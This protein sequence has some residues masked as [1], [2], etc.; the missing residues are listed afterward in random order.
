M[1]LHNIQE[2]T[3]RRQFIDRGDSSLKEETVFVEEGDSSSSS[4]IIGRWDT[5]HQERT[6]VIQEGDNSL[7][8][9][10]GDLLME[11]VIC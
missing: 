8:I 6:L 2:G 10:G 5:S 3:R 11:E 1:S 9:E 7:S 4:E